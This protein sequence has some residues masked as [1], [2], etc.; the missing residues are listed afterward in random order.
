MKSLIIIIFFVTIQF[1]NIKCIAAKRLMPT[2][3]KNSFIF[4]Y[5]NK[6][7]D[8]FKNNL[9]KRFFKIQIYYDIIMTD[10]GKL[11]IIP[12]DKNRNHYFIG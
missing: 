9:S 2:N 10:D 4:D 7:E 8:N 12:I 6:S 5:N 1:L 3:Q 11:F